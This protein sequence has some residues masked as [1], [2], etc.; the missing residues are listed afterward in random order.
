MGIQRLN[1]EAIFLGPVDLSPISR[2]FE[3][4]DAAIRAWKAQ[5][6]DGVPPET[7]QVRPDIVRALRA[8][9]LN[10]RDGDA[11]MMVFGLGGPNPCRAQPV[12]LSLWEAFA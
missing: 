11:Y 8:I 12:E 9:A 5:N 4:M 1:S 7:P 2:A 6:S 3:R 10:A